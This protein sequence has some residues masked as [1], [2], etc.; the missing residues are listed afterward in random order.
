[1]S[2]IVT[3]LFAVSW[4]SIINFVA[5][6]LTG[7][8]SSMVFMP[9]YEN[10][11]KQ[12]IVESVCISDNV[13]FWKLLGVIL[14]QVAVTGVISQELRALIFPGDALDPTGG[15]F[16]MIGLMMTIGA[17]HIVAAVDNIMCFL[18]TKLIPIKKQQKLQMSEK[19]DGPD[20]LEKKEGGTRPTEDGY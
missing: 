15:L 7:K 19:A 9:A 10:L 3:D 13:T 17:S 20:T 1:M 2:L 5:G 14:A 8:V 11:Q 6:T 16:F 18:K 12:S 4:Y